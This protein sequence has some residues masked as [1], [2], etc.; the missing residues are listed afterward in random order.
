MLMSSV[1]KSVASTPLEFGLVLDSSQ[2]VAAIEEALNSIFNLSLRHPQGPAAEFLLCRV[3]WFQEP[4]CRLTGVFVKVVRWQKKS[5]VAVAYTIVA[6]AMLTN[7]CEAAADCLCL[8]LEGRHDAALLLKCLRDSYPHKNR[9]VEVL[10]NYM[11]ALL[12]VAGRNPVVRAPL[13]SIV[14]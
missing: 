13:L 10:L 14:C 2:P 4:Y 1:A 8:L 6:E 9:A 11:Q 7:Q 12:S 5:S 3:P